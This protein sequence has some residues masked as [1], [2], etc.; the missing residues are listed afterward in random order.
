MAGSCVCNFL[1]SLY[2]VWPFQSVPNQRVLEQPAKLVLDEQEA[3]TAPNLLVLEFTYPPPSHYQ[4]GGSLDK[5][6]K[7]A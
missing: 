4:P 1:F 5:P 7:I 3:E 2:E 6:K